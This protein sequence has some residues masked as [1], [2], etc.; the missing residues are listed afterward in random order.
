[1][2]FHE[3]QIRN[4]Y[5]SVARC[6]YLAIHDHDIILD[7]GLGGERSERRGWG[8]VIGVRAVGDQGWVGGEFSTY[9]RVSVLN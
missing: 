1:M 5:H 8:R 9:G 2:F 7:T 3:T 4:T 6:R